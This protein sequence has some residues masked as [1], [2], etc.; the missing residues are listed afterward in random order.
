MLNELNMNTCECG[1]E[2][3]AGCLAVDLN[4]APEPLDLRAWI[5][6]TACE[7]KKAR[8]CRVRRLSGKLDGY[9]VNSENL[10]RSMLGI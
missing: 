3:E 9:R 4:A 2:Y 6:K 1:Y 7:I 5:E 8:S 10:A